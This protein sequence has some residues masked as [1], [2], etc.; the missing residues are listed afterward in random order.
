MTGNPPRTSILAIAKG[1]DASLEWL[2]LG[3]G[4]APPVAGGGET[5]ST[6]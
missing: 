4:E 3:V 6:L 1:T 5:I 2:L